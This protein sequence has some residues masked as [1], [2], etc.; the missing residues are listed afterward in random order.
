MLNAVY[1]AKLCSG[2]DKDYGG[3][4]LLLKMPHGRWQGSWR[5][6]PTAGAVGAYRV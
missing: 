5:N 6:L 2:Y 4:C 3:T 1:A